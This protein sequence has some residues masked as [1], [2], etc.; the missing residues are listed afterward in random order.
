L[1]SAAEGPSSWAAPRHRVEAISG[2]PGT[3]EAVDGVEQFAALL[4]GDILVAGGE[5]AATQ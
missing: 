5:R 3:S 1:S 4:G 2:L